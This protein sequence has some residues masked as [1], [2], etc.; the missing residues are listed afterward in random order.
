MRGTRGSSALLVAGS[1]VCAAARATG[2]PTQDP[3]GTAAL[4][5]TVKEVA[6][7]RRLAG[8]RVGLKTRLNVLIR[9]VVTDRNGA[10]TMSDLAADEYLVVSMGADYTADL[11]RVKTHESEHL[12]KT[13]YK[14]VVIRGT[15]VA[16]HRQPVAGAFVCALRQAREDGLM[17]FVPV[18]HGVTDPHGVYQIAQ[19]DSGASI[20]PGS[21]LVGVLP[22][23]CPS[24]GAI[25]L[26]DTPVSGYPP[27]YFPG[28]SSPARAA[29]LAL[30][31]LDD[32]ID[33]NLQLIPGPTARVDGVVVHPGVADA[34]LG[35][36]ILEPPDDVVA[37]DRATR[38]E[39]AGR[40]VFR[41]VE[42]GRYR[43]L[44]S[45]GAATRVPGRWAEGVITVTDAPTASVTLRLQPAMAI[46]GVVRL[47]DGGAP[48]MDATV[49][50]SLVGRRVATML[51][52]PPLLSTI[53]PGG[54][55]SITG[56]MPGAYR[57]NVDG[58][59]S[60]EWRV[61]SI[62]TSGAGTTPPNA[63]DAADVP[64]SITA[65]RAISAAITL[66]RSGTRISGMADARDG[67]PAPLFV[68]ILPADRE[69]WT[70]ESAPTASR[71]VVRMM[72]KVDGS[73]ASPLLPDGDYLV[74]A[75]PVTGEPWSGEDPTVLEALQ[76]EHRW[77][78]PTILD[79]LRIVSV[80]VHVEEGHAPAVTVRV[81]VGRE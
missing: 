36:V 2:L 70:H 68:F 21:Y 40:F 51:L 64:L 59:E 77:M 4:T 61:K 8:V 6:T 48:P 18:G 81:G 37:I 13:F 22:T 43:I 3:Q 60:S 73:F 78:Q 41:D 63:S 27:T 23:G 10:F 12:E 62:V 38:I 16:D 28:T 29:V 15:V 9:D 7:G 39:G 35:R 50:A 33:L 34:P 46:D 57:L 75:V 42:P 69:F 32:R 66:T 49:V 1:L 74:A 67:T 17:R 19:R 58:I 45:S 14:G 79:T 11:D 30:D 26:T 47:D 71:R 76:S 80:P 52:F 53:G 72:S 31:A 20:E 25:W 5:G 44:V 54:R 55:F 24:E 65:G 56:V